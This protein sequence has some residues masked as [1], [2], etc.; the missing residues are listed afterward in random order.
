MTKLEKRI[1][2]LIGEGPRP[3]SISP[4][5]T[6]VMWRYELVKRLAKDARVVTCMHENTFDGWGVYPHSLDTHS[7]ILLDI[8]PRTQKVTKAEILRVI[9]ATHGNICSGTMDNLNDMCDRIE[10]FGIEE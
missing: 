9:R 5:T 8:Q 4:H 3:D 7:A 1:D 2:E 10:E 6:W